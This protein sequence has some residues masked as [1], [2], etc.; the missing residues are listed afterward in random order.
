MTDGVSNQRQLVLLLGPTAV[1][2]TAVACALQSR[3]AKPSRLIS[4]DSTLVYR[5]MDIG[6][7]KPSADEL[8]AHPHELIDI[9]NPEEIY[10]AADFVQDADK[11]VES[12]FASDEIPI[13]V[14]GSMLY[15]KRFLEGIARLPQ[16]DPAVRAALEEEFARNGGALLHE[17][18]RAMDPQAAAN[19]HP[20]NPQR[21]IRALEVVRLTQ[22]PLSTLWR[23]QSTPSAVERIRAKI[24]VFALLPDDRRALHS[25]IE[26]R[27]EA[28]LAA[29]FETELRRLAARPGM[30][31]DLPA[32]RAVG[33][34]QGMQYLRGELD[35]EGFRQQTLTATRR[36]AKRQLTWLRQWQD[37]HR[38]TWGE[39]ERI[40]A[41][42]AD[43]ISV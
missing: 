8:K 12:A 33:Y 29:G 14:G 18:L 39:A 21:L 43:E 34:R 19:I 15:A 22:R 37:I 24:T 1:G 9:R 6:S 13:M 42:L 35:A 5:G 11:C 31:P 32:M 36:L 7:A 2:K 16:A 28:M 25:L 10:T 27:F 17:Q 26:Q 40:A 4:V 20:N 38:L 3:L 30:H 23:E 41:Q